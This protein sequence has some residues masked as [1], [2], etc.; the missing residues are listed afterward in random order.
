MKIKLSNHNI[1][2]IIYSVIIAI[3]LW[4]VVSI[5]Q[6]PSVQKTI[7]HIPVA[8]DI[9]GTVASENG[10]SVISCDVE[11]VTVELL[12][13]R[14]QVGS[15]NNENLVA[16]IDAANV[17]AS[18]TKN[19]TI[20]VRSA[21]NNK[22]NYEIQSVY[23]P[24]ATVVLDRYDTREFSINPKTPNV[25][26]AE[27]KAINSEEFLCEPGI[28]KITGPSAQLDKIS[29]CYAVANTE[30]SLADSY[31]LASDEIQLFTED[32][33]P[34]D[35]TGMTFGN[36]NFSINIPIRI[37]KTVGLYVSIANAPADFDQSI[38]KFNMSADSVVL[39]ANSSATAIPDNIEIGKIFLSDLDINYSKT[40]SLK[41]V[42][43]GSEYINV[44]D[45]D[46]VTVSLN[47]EGLE[48][49]DLTL[50]RSRITLS[51]SPDSS[52][53]YYILTQN[54]TISVVGPENIISEITSEDIIADVNLLNA[55]TSV[56]Q[57]NASVTFSCPQY[58]DVW[59][60]T[61]SKVS[62]LKKKIVQATTEPPKDTD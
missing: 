7:E 40:F 56:D 48:K 1:S 55:D 60:V 26:I 3:I 41:R 62:V 18:G 15:L 16:Y 45:L 57:F 51:N 30:L 36:T 38:L 32:G 43:E 24:T 8:T 44:S 20:R 58:N 34:I 13:S 37:Q 29:K 31:T 12:G 17:S 46:N 39:A 10:L 47:S 19:M 52:Y 53:D 35:Q 23:P 14:T 59:V 21:A 5:T 61:S 49:T 9:T 25:T 11:E 28:I 27:G 50:D 6:Y 2:T 42:L 22:I 33:T 54:M 4:F